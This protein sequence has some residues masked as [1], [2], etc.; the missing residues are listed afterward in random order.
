MFA[1]RRST[2]LK[3]P[4]SWLRLRYSLLLT[5]QLLVFLVY[6]FVIDGRFGPAVL[7]VFVS[8]TVLS[9]AQSLEP[10]DRRLGFILAVPTALLFWIAIAT[11]DPRPLLGMAIIGTGCVGF[12]SSRIFL[13]AL[14]IERVSIEKVQGS[15]AVFLL[16][17]LNWALVF[18]ILETFRPGSFNLALTTTASGGPI[19]GTHLRAF[20][21]LLFHSYMTLCATSYGNV[22]AVT[23]PALAL[24][25]FE[26][27]VGQIYQAILV[28]QLMGLHLAFHRSRQAQ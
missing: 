2:A 25:A 7:G 17:G 1:A 19:A 22:A 11:D 28:G 5:T 10:G 12:L 27:L 20:S 4:A 23:A 8:A 6:P 14:Q 3:W 13:H 9:A 16:L 24:S 15:L 26:T 21:H 18:A